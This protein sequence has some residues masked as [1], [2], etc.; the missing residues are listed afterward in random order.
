MPKYENA[1][2]VEMALSVIAM[3]EALGKCGY[4]LPVLYVSQSQ[5]ATAMWVRDNAKVNISIDA[6]LEPLEW[7]VEWH[8][9]RVGSVGH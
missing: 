5:E 8:G 9:K 1:G 6:E 2:P 7:Y 4:Q 3:Y